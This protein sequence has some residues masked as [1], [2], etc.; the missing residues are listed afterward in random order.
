MVLAP[1]KIFQQIWWKWTHYSRSVRNKSSIYADIKKAID[2]VNHILLIRKMVKFPLKNSFLKWFICYFENRRQTVI[3]HTGWCFTIGLFQCSIVSRPGICFG[4]QYYSWYFST[5]S[6][7]THSCSISRTIR[8][9]FK[10]FVIQ[11]MLHFYNVRWPFVLF[12]LVW[13]K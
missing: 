6:N 12:E 8:K 9:L 5:I 11:M 3:C 13:F 4:S 10:G 7:S 2:A 1:I